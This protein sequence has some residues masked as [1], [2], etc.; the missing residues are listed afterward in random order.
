MKIN[1]VCVGTIKEK[2]LTEAIGE[3]TKR[4][5]R[6]ATCNIIEV[7]EEKLPN[8]YSDADIDHV[9]E[10]ESERLIEKISGHAILLDIK[11]KMLDSVQFSRKIE[12]IK[13]SSSTISFIIGGS[14]GVSDKLKNLCKDSISISY[15]TFPH[16]LMRVILLEQIY[17]AF[18]ISNHITYHK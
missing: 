13:Q 11:G 9:K 14:Y 2:Y 12:D 4:I 5:S 8:N 10:C 15:M 18:T 1:I 16:Q 17:R 3:Y 6:F 7:K